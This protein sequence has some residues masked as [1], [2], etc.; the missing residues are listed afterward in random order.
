MRILCLYTDLQCHKA[1]F[2]IFDGVAEQIIENLRQLDAIQ[3]ILMLPDGFDIAVQPQRFC[4][5][6][7][8]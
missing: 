3:Q 6:S 5:A 7:A 8:V 4:A 2:S 1:P